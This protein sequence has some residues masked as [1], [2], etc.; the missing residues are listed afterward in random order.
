MTSQP[1]PPQATTERPDAARASRL[2]VVIETNNRREYTDR[3]L[4]PSDQVG[5]AIDALAAQQ[6]V[7]SV[8]ILLVTKGGPTAADRALATRPHVSIIS[9]DPG[10]SY[11]EVHNAGGCAATTEYI[12]FVDSDCIPHP[13]WVH[14]AV[15][16][17]DGGAD[18]V[19]GRSQYAD[20]GGWAHAMSFFDFGSIGPRPDGSATQF[21][22][23]NSA[24]RRDVFVSHQLETRIRRSGGGYLAAARLRADHRV[25][26]YNPEMLV[27]HGNDYKRGLSLG[28]RL[29][30]G[31]DA[32]VL[33]RVDDTGVL[34]HRWILLLGPLAAPLVAGKRIWDDW[35]RLRHRRSDLGISVAEVPVLVL[36]SIPMRLI[37]GG[38]YAVSSVW[39]SI[40]GK[41]WR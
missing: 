28:K 11:Y 39:P 3:G 18:V 21:I 37:E 13:R 12:G 27:A 29:R 34:P 22:L 1:T 25:V 31:H 23:S 26:A 8:E 7:R 9:V 35:G 6:E 41:Y 33:L 20:P 2:T 14:T 10:A 17:L 40:I 36:L 30:N 5:R 4:A 24:F 32:A 19:T 38:A 16:T 15:A